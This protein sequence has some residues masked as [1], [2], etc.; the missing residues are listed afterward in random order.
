ME[1]T[2]NLLALPEDCIATVISFT[3]PL[4]ACR[5]SS[6]SAALRSAAESDTVWERFLPAEFRQ[7]PASSKK[8]LFLSLSDIPLLVENGKMSL[9]LER[10]SGK[11]CYMLSARE[12]MITWADSPAYWKWTSIHESRFAE[13]AELV[14]VCWLEIRGRIHI[15]V[16][17]KETVY[18]AY[19]VFKQKRS[20]GFDYQPVE[21]SFGPADS[22]ADKRTVFLAT[23]NERR[24]GYHIQTRH[25]GLVS[26]ENGS[27]N[28][29]SRV[30]T[31]DKTRNHISERNDGWLEVEL[32]EYFVKAGAEEELEMSILEISGG[33]WKGGLLIQGIEIRP[34]R[35]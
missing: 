13:V 15:S 34:K 29:T 31:D 11:K 24:L 25:Y 7:S 22:K 2:A 10:R 23:G 32:G 6:V 16:L 9:T 35:V 4:D 30:D 1:T 26:T 19:L 28:Q 20:Y 33:N 8:E 18:T 5:I 12:L 3:S 17:S 21:A 14:S 27:G